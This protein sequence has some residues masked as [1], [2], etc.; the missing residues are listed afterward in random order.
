VA[1]ESDRPDLRV[2]HPAPKARPPVVS[3]EVLGTAIFVFTEI[4]LFAGFVSAFTIARAQAPMWPPPGQPR[5]PI[6]ETAFN[7]AALLASGALVWWAGRL[8]ERK[9]PASARWPLV[10]GAALGAFFVVFQGFEWLGLL[11]DGM[12][13]TASNYG[14][15]FYLI[16]GAHALHVVG[17]LTVLCTMAARLW[18]ERLT[19]SGFHAGRLFWYFVVLLWPVLYWKVYL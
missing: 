5:L 12:T 3:S 1:S 4:M 11:R 13:L 7:T 15:F 6:E 17:G 14:S 19:T 9:G 10:A 16:V 18:S 8:F 2:V